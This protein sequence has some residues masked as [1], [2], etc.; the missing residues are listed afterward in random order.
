LPGGD[1]GGSRDSYTVQLRHRYNW[2][3]EGLARR[4]TRTYGSHSELILANATR[5]ESLGEHFGHG[6]YEAELRYLVENEWVVE[7]DDAIWRRTK[8]GMALSDEEKQR[9]AQW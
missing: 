3:P 1:I 6:L 8:L 2:L 9:V 7:L 4:Y 5:L